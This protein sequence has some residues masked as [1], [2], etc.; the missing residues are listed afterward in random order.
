MLCYKVGE[1]RPNEIDVAYDVLVETRAFKLPG[2][3]RQT[4]QPL[5][6]KY[7]FYIILYLYIIVYTFIDISFY[8]RQYV[9]VSLAFR[10]PERRRIDSGSKRRE[11]SSGLRSSPR[12]RK[13]GLSTEGSSTKGASS[14]S[15]CNT[16]SDVCDSDSNESL[17]N[18]GEI[19]DSVDS[20]PDENVVH[21][22]TQ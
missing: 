14:T 10:T 13:V 16:E 20:P 1:E 21:S 19:E 18:L 7:F 17:A 12:K 15:S 3:N 9:I 11:L 4:T 6:Y 8:F 5:R 22:Q 2:R